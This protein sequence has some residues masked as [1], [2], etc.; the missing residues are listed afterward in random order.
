MVTLTN[1]VFFEK[2]N[3]PDNENLKE[4]LKFTN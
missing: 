3:P 4:K 2:R 1:F